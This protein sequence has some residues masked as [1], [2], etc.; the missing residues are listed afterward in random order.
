MRLILFDLSDQLGGALGDICM[1][2]KVDLNIGVRV[3]QEFATECCKVVMKM[4]KHA[5]LPDRI[6]FYL[7]WK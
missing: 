3:F 1:R 7:F 4:G 5:T 2:F 6:R